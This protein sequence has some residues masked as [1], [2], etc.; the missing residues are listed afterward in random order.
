M[1]IGK[2]MAVL[3]VLALGGCEFLAKHV[4][5]ESDEHSPFSAERRDAPIERVDGVSIE[6]R[7]PLAL[8]GKEQQESK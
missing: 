8:D 6:W 7:L 1:T 3:A 5:I 2:R 4:R